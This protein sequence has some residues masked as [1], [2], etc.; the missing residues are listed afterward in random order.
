[1]KDII[2]EAAKLITQSGKTVALTGAG[3]S[4]ESG[5]DPF[6][7]EAGIWKKYKPEEYATID[8][9]MA[10]P[11]K[12]W[13]ML[14][15]LSATIANA[16]PNQ[17]HKAL[18]EL[19]TM[20]KLS[21]IITQN[22]DSLHHRAG[23]TH[24]IELHGNNRQLKC[25]ECE[26][27]H[28]VSR[29]KIEKIPPRCSCGGI[30]RPDVVFFGEPLPAD[31]IHYANQRALAADL[32]LVIGTSAIVYPAASLPILAKGAGARIIEINQEETPFTG[33]ISD[34]LLKGKAGE[35]MSRL[36]KEVKEEMQH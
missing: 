6:R 1:M 16:Q 25:L 20:G 3:I 2:K 24:V 36:L 34:F 15:E 27:I 17:A 33:T 18:A 8:A 11:T 30:L 9:F 26:Q 31:A 23:S 7:G 4:V 35:I 22:V 10:N 5:I 14:Q 29:D 12:V 19:E 28:Q 21:M 32:M 13:K